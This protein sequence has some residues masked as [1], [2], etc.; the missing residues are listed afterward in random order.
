[1][2]TI[3]DLAFSMRHKIDCIKE[4]AYCDS[5]QA[6]IDYVLSLANDATNKL[7]KDHCDY[8]INEVIEKNFVPQLN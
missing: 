4:S 3:D 7:T 1:M 8:L 2:L 6:L 5:K